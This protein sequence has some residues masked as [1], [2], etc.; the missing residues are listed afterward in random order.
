MIPEYFTNN[1]LFLTSVD[2]F[3]RTVIHNTLSSNSVIYDEIGNS[4]EWNSTYST[5]LS[6][7]SLWLNGGG[8]L[9]NNITSDLTVGAISAGQILEYGTSLQDFAEKLL[10]KIFYPTFTSPSATLTSNLS[11][12]V[13]SGT[14]N[15]TL[16]VNLNKGAITGKSVDGI[17][18]TTLFQNFRSGNATKYT[19][20]G[21]DNGT[22]VSYT[23]ADAMVLDGSNVF[24]ATVNYDQGPQP[25]DSKNNN[26]LTPLV[27]GSL[28]PTLTINGRRRAFYGVNNVASNSS[29]IRSLSNSLLNPS[30]GSSFTINIPTG[31]TDVVFAYPAS[32]RDVTEVKYVEGLGSDVKANFTKTLVNVEG[33]N[34]YSAIQYKVYKYTPTG[35][36]G[37]NVP[38]SQNVTYIVTI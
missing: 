23:S 7:S 19:I 36:G 37:V 31:S 3:G 22:T 38:F 11:N 9:V 1:V 25:V 4:T 30:N 29:E 24:S 13:E 2:V 32:L 15:I 6:N 14:K 34:N 5:V 21:V 10:L 27:A 8:T 20:F 17:W 26:Y 18:Q 12:N 28:T 33:L 35:V 16:T